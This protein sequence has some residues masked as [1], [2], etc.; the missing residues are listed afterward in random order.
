[1]KKLFDRFFSAPRWFRY[2]AAGGYNTAFSFALFT[3]LYFLLKDHISYLWVLIINHII[4]VFHSFVVM[5]IFV[6]KTKGNF[7]K[8]YLKC[9]VTYASTLAINFV[10]LYVMVSLLDFNVLISQFVCTIAIAALT[11]FLHKGFSFKSRF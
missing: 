10:S 5:K 9:N 4:S 3:A 8:E 7:F 6:F 11:Y 1:M 2:L